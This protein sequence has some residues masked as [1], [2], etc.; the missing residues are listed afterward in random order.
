MKILCEFFNISFIKYIYGY[1]SSALGSSATLTCRPNSIKYLVNN[2]H[3]CFCTAVVSWTSALAWATWSQ[4]VQTIC[5]GGLTHSQPLH[6]I[7]TY[8][9]SMYHAS[10]FSNHCF[11][12]DVNLAPI[13]RNLVTAHRLH[14]CITLIPFR[15]SWKTPCRR[16]SSKWGIQ[17]YY[18]RFFM[19]YGVLLARKCVFSSPLRSP[20][21]AA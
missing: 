18:G 21:T 11:G 20:C 7:F 15:D 17:N 4:T 14:I 13:N 1:Q 12:H 6:Q 3:R 10:Q 19:G 2:T 16:K 5:P 9:L 8:Y